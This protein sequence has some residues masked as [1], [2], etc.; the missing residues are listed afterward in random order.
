MG[1]LAHAL[2]CNV[3]TLADIQELVLAGT[4]GSMSGRLKPLEGLNVKQLRKELES[5]G[6]T[7]KGKLKPQLKD[8]LTTILSGV[9]RVPTVLILDPKQ[10]L[11]SLNLQRYE[12]LDCEQLHDMKEHLRNLLPEVPHLLPPKLK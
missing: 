6:S 3:R 5:R 10:P 4:Y 2:Q 1:D 12:V 8:E 9:Q 11:S 7:T